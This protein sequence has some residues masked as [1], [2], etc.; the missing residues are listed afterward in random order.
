MTADPDLACAG[1]CFREEG[2]GIDQIRIM[3]WIEALGG[4]LHGCFS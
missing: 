4:G 2:V 1:F 3:E